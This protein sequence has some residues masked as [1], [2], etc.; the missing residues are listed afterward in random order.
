M[1]KIIIVLLC[2][3]SLSGCASFQFLNKLI[4]LPPEGPVT[5]VGKVPE[6]L[7]IIYQGYAT[8][9]QSGHLTASGKKFYPDKFT[10]A[11]RT[12]PFGTIL[13]L[14]NPENGNSIKVV[15]NDRGPHRKKIHYDVSRGSAKALGFIKKGVTKLHIELQQPQ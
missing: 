4:Q 6:E 12:L 5:P 1:K 14:T 10:V 9:Y 15:V 13:K 2:S 11:H 8:W 3:F 7:N